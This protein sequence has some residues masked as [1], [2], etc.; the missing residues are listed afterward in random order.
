M[1]TKIILVDDHPIFRQGLQVL[2]EEHENYEVIAVAGDGRT[3]L[4]LARDLSP[5]VIVM[6]I[7]LP[8]LNGIEATRAILKELGNIKIVAL[9]IHNSRIFI[10]EM[11]SAGAMGYVL[12][13][14]AF[15][16]L[17]IAIETV[18]NGE[19]Y[20]SKKIKCFSQPTSLSQNSEKT[21][22]DIR[23]LTPREKEVLQLIAEGKSS[24]EISHILHITLKTVEKH[25]HGIKEKLDIYSTAQLTKFAIQSSLTNLDI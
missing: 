10:D 9:S 21:S 22:G 2:I 12:K 7:T 19:Q 23:S 16:E 8:E 15:E 20:L 3:T 5:D 17:V 25:R 11:L 18:L 1:K 13:S 24:K 6:D 4:Q 14:C